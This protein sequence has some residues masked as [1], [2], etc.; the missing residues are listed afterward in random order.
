M[1]FWGDIVNLH[2]ELVP[3]IPRDVI[4]MPWGYEADHPFDIESARMAAAG[5]PFYVCPGTSTWTSWP[6]APPM[7]WATCSMPPKMA[8]SMAQGLPQYG[9]GRPRSLAGAA[10]QLPGFCRRGCVFLEPGHQP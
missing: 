9:L 6:G 3:E 4:G 8:L 2:P 5:L 10:G 1:Q 7:P